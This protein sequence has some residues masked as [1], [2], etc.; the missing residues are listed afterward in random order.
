MRGRVWTMMTGLALAGGLAAGLNGCQERRPA[1]E[2]PAPGEIMP[3][4]APGL[5][6]EAV[7]ADGSA[8]TRRIC[9]DAAAAR[10]LNLMGDELARFRCVANRT[11]RDGDGWSFEHQCDLLSD[12]RQEVTGHVTGDLAR[13][14]AM[15][16]TSIVEGAAFAQAN[17][18]H[19]TRIEAELEGPCPD[20]WRPGE[21]R[22]EN[23]ER[24]S[25]L[26]TR[27]MR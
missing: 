10:R 24:F 26:N 22:L 23:G 21:V 15:T 13:R 17:G 14:W 18:R 7:T 4:R 1:G 8:Q 20:G 16:A 2:T 3:N 5:W 9:L 27:P 25:L 12:G 19:Q 11:W 6:R